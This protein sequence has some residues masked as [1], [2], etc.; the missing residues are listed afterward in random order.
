MVRDVAGAPRAGGRRRPGPWAAAGLLD[1]PLSRRRRTRRAA[2]ATTTTSAMRVRSR[3]NRRRGLAVKVSPTGPLL[4][5]APCRPGRRRPALDCRNGPARGKMEHVLQDRG[6]PMYVGMSKEQE[7]L[8]DELRA[9]L[10]RAPHARGR[11]RHSQGRRRRPE[12]EGQSGRRWPPTATPASAGRRSGAAGASRPSS[13]SCSSTSR[14]A[15]ARR[16]RCSRSTRSRRRSCATAAR[17][18][19]SSTCRRSSKARST[20]RSATPSPTP[21]PTSRR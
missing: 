4:C 13:S 14:C 8:R 1:P 12:V 2:T 17:S 9:V 18:R 19:S 10:R 3:Q 5:R 21:A 16:C 20:S 15:R 11:R 6:G 7:A